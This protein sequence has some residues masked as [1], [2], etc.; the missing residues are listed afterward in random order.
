MEWNPLAC[1]KNNVLGTAALASLAEA[2]GVKQFVMISTDKAVN[3]RGIMGLSKRLAERVILERHPSRTLFNLVRFGNVL[4]SSG[5]VI[6]LFQKQI[7]DGGPVT[8]TSP[9]TKRFFMSIPEAVQL[10]L[11]ASTLNEKNAIFMLEMGEPIKIIELAKKLIEL[12]GFR[13][14]DDIEIKITG[15][16]PGEKI[17]EELLAKQENCI[18]TPFEK[19]RLQKNVNYDPDRVNKFLHHLKSHLDLGNV[20]AIYAEIVQLV[21]EMTGPS[22]EEIMN[23]MFN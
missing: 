18:P 12:S 4:G 20:K 5:S 16:R 3:P 21:P 17:E 14:G 19:I 13:V 2:H 8:V 6:P 11:Q 9:D 10:V 23:N 22:F 1:L 7:R 15:M